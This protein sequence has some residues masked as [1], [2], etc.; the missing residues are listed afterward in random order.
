MPFVLDDA[1]HL[2]YT[3]G[4]TVVMRC[5]PGTGALA[6]IA[7]SDAPGEASAFRGGSQGV[8][9]DDGFLFAVHEVQRA[10]RSLLYL[11]RFVLLDGSLRLAA[12]SPRFTFTGDHVEFCAGMARRG[13]ELVLSF[14]VSDAAAGLAVVPLGAAVALLE[15]VWHAEQPTDQDDGD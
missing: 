1:L 13:E 12:V 3:C 2:V 5:D 9:V 7:E 14:G 4:P 10:P 11:H 15:P 8:A 6:V